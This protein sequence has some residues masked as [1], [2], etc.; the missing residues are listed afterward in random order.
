MENPPIPSDF[1]LISLSTTLSIASRE[2]QWI[3]SFLWNSQLDMPVTTSDFSIYIHIHNGWSYSHD[4]RYPMTKSIRY[5]PVGFHGCQPRPVTTV[6]DVSCG[7]CHG[8]LGPI[9]VKQPMQPQKD[10]QVDHHQISRDL[11]DFYLSI[12]FS[13][14]Y[15]WFFHTPDG[16]WNPISRGERTKLDLSWNSCKTWSV[17]FGIDGSPWFE[18]VNIPCKFPRSIPAGSSQYKSHLIKNV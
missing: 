16:R 17:L 9:Q 6:H 7:L 11:L 2:N 13:W 4:V 18:L 10:R 3:D 12:F 15:T 14:V 8:C 5:L 1:L